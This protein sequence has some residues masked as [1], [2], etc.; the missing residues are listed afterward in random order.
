MTAKIT[1]IGDLDPATRSHL[2]WML[3][4]K[5]VETGD[6]YQQAFLRALSNG[7][8]MPDDP[9][10]R[11]WVV[12]GLAGEL[13]EKRGRGRPRRKERPNWLQTVMERGIADLY[14]EWLRAFKEDRETAWLRAESSRL[15]ALHPNAPMWRR[16]YDLGKR[17]DRRRYEA[18]LA[19]LGARPCP[20]IQKGGKT[21]R[22]LALTA[23]AEE[24]R[25]VWQSATQGPLTEAVVARI[26][27]RERKRARKSE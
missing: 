3:A 8:Q 22:E 10:D 5:E 13:D 18:A 6:S 7:A 17:R 21:P 25:K 9:E 12:K 26:V 1:A 2:A 24:R 20:P 4:R 14:E 11:E 23:T 19:K 16:L 27:T 15:R